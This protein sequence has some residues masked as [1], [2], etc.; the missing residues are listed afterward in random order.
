MLPKKSRAGVLEASRWGRNER[1][2]PVSLLTLGRG[3]YQR[4]TVHLASVIVDG[5]CGLGAEVAG[6]GVEVERGDTVGAVRAVELHA[7]LD[8]L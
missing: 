7:A 3:N 4:L 1:L 8:A 2:A 5:G 6:L